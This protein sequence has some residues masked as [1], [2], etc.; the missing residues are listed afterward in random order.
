MKIEHKILFILSLV[1]FSCHVN[2]EVLKHI[3]QLSRDHYYIHLKKPIFTVDGLVGGEHENFYH[4]LA[5]KGEAF[6]LSFHAKGAQPDWSVSGEG[7]VV[8]SKGGITAATSNLDGNWITVS[9][10]AYPET[11]EYK[12]EIIRH[13]IPAEKY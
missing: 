13:T 8:R 11:T 6:T 2:A 7:I 10:S 1:F 4:I 5:F 9:V 12:I 3:E